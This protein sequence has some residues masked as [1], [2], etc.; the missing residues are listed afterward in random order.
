MNRRV[1]ACELI[2]PKMVVIATKVE[3]NSR[4]LTYKEIDR[5]AWRRLVASSKTGTWFQGPEAYAFL[6][7][8]PELFRPFVL[9]V[10]SL[11]LPPKGKRVEHLP[12]LQ[13]RTEYRLILRGVCVGYVTVE[14]SAVKQFFTRRAIIL[15]GPVIADDATDAEVT[16]LLE[17]VRQQFKIL[18]FRFL[19]WDSRISEGI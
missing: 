12:S 11:Q 3:V 9:G 1:G 16:A 13:G 6:A 7:S 4:V 15:G 14:K 19:I 18:D 5:E 10:A 2:T 8:M 17:A